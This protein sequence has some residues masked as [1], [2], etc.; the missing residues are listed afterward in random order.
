MSLGEDEAAPQLLHGGVCMCTVWAVHGA[1]CMECLHVH[2]CV[3][4]CA[5]LPAAPPARSSGRTSSRRCSRG[6]SSRRA[7]AVW[8]WN[9][10]RPRPHHSHSRP[11]HSHSRPHRSHSL[12]PEWR[13]GSSRVRGAAKSLEGQ[14]R[15]AG[16]GSGLWRCQDRAFS[17]LCRRSVPSLSIPDWKTDCERRQPSRRTRS[18][19]SR[20]LPTTLLYDIT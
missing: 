14:P 9:S 12:G 2:V 11:H 17:T 3:C 7:A 1:T 19:R 10:Q 16:V 15:E 5:V 4:T 6:S 20:T 18:C 13:G 8:M